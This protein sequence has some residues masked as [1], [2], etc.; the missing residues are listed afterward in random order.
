MFKLI[1]VLTAFTCNVVFQDRYI[2]VKHN[3]FADQLS[4]FHLKKTQFNSFVEV[5]DYAEDVMVRPLPTFT[6]QTR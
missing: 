4:H 2:A 6:L 1:L 5:F 3:T